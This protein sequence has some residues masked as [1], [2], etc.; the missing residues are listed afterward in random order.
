MIRPVSGPI[1]R[2]LLAVSGI[3]FWFALRRFLPGGKGILADSFFSVV[4]VVP[5][6]VLGLIGVPAAAN[7]FGTRGFKW[8]LLIT[9]VVLIV[10]L[11]TF[12]PG[13]FSPSGDAPGVVALTL[14]SLGL[15]AI[16][17]EL[18]FRLFLTDVLS[19]GRRFVVGSLVSSVLFTVVH[20]DNPFSNPLGML[21]VFLAG[22]GLCFLRALG[23]GMAG[24]VG[25]HYL[26]NAGVGVFMGMRVSGYHF[27]ALF[28]PD[29]LPAGFGPE[30]SPFLTGAL[31]T[32]VATGAVKLHR[33]GRCV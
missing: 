1:P 17:E 19:L 5:V 29:R 12:I 32:L 16:H 18:L 9:A 27:P 28:R 8:S 11:A 7:R 2:I 6:A 14:L 30:S 25:A 22:M 31:L 21:N 4:S 33:K 13:G 15:Y 26:W 20:L 3:L 24:A 10:P 23:G